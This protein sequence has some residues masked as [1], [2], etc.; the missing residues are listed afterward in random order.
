MTDFC[1]SIMFLCVT[2]DVASLVL[3]ALSCDC[4][5]SCCVVT[6]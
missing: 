6:A 5:F 2:V 4:S 3:I 1:V